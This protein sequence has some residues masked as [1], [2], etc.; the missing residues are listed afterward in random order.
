MHSLWK[1][2]WRSQVDLVLLLF[3]FCVSAPSLEFQHSPHAPLP[4]GLDDWESTDLVLVSR[5]IDIC[6][7][8]TSSVFDGVL[9]YWTTLEVEM[10][11]LCRRKE[12]G[13]KGR[14]DKDTDYLSSLLAIRAVW[15]WND[16][17]LQCRRSPRWMIMQ[18][19]CCLAW[20]LNPPPAPVFYALHF[21]HV[22]LTTL[23]GSPQKYF[24]I[25]YLIYLNKFP[26]MYVGAGILILMV[27]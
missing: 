20:P 3:S 8:N 26:V 15:K 22:S 7:S 6:S 16:L 2:A 13:P 1:P 27:Q 24:H 4:T 19:R 10:F 5:V 25:Y 21:S 18:K 11:S 9:L 17:Q 23:L 12:I 14:S